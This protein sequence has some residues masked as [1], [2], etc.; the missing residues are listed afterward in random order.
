MCNNTASRDDLLVKHLIQTLN[1]IEFD[2]Y[3]DLQPES[4]DSW[5]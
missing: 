2:W 4:I 5:E 3:T 1:G